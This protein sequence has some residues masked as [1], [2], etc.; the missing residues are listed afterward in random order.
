MCCLVLCSIERNE[1]QTGMKAG[2]EF[3]SGLLTEM[4]FKTGIRFSYVQI[5][6][7]I[8]WVSADSLG[9]AFY[10]LVRLK[11]IASVIT[12]RPFWQKWSFISSD[13]ISC[14]HWNEMPTHIHQNIGSF[15]SAS[16]KKRHVNRTCF[17]FVSQVY[18]LLKNFPDFKDT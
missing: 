18:V 14:K 17:H 9:I 12:Y 3:I 8:K 4:K 10:S 15:W 7:E 6:L 1:T 2:M 5:L 16:E 11:L 13:K